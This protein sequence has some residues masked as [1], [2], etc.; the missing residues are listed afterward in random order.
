MAQGPQS[1]NVAISSDAAAPHRRPLIV[2]EATG[3]LRISAPNLTTGSG[4]AATILNV[5][6]AAVISE[7]ATRLVTVSVIAAGDAGGG[8]L[9]LNDS[10]TIAGAA[11]GNRIFSKSADDMKAGDIYN[12]DLPTSSGLTVS[13]APTNSQFAI[14]FGS[15][16]GEDAGANR[17]ATVYYAN[18]PPF[19]V[20]TGS[21][22]AD[23][24]GNLFVMGDNGAFEQVGYG[25]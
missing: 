9:V 25:W 8:S 19:G 14:S 18:T 11:A 3:A 5:V 23:G 12:A 21:I 13:E 6:D 2:D 10:P 1:S 4:A 15:M 24:D 20:P 16:G 22:W 7:K 17:G